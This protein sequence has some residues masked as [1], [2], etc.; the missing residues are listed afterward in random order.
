MKV[1]IIG[2]GSIAKYLVDELLLQ[3]HCV[4]AISRSHKQW[5]DDLNIKQHEVQYTAIELA[6]ALEGSDV[7]LCT[8]SSSSLELVEIHK[9]ILEAIKSVPTIKRFI[10]SVWVGNFEDVRDQPY[11]GADRIQKIHDLLT[12]QSAVEWT[13]LSVGWLVDYVIPASQRYLHDEGLWVQ[14]DKEKTFKLY[15]NGT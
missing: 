13:L 4:V 1:A 6:T 9:V 7:A 14:N 3:K 12:Q 11:Y 15:G 10:P 5:L 8:V 2:T